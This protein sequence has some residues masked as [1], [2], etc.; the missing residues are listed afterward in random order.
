MK[1]TAGRAICVIPVTSRRD[2]NLL[3][4]VTAEEYR[5]THRLWPDSLLRGLCK[6]LVSAAMLVRYRCA[7]D[8]QGAHSIPISCCILYILPYARRN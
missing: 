3:T 5:A 2:P 7:P 1:Q 6:G 8:C 4:R